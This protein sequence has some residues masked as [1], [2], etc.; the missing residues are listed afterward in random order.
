MVPASPVRRMSALDAAFLYF[1]RP[2][3]PLSIGCV[4][5][6]EGRLTRDVRA[7][8]SGITSAT[9]ALLSR[10]AR[11]SCATRSKT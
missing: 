2:H 4:A 9:W 10:E 1:D 3:S 11:R 7:S 6:L 5:T 8:T